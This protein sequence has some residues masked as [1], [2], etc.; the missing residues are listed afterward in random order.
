MTGHWLVGHVAH[1][2]GGQSWIVDGAAVQGFDVGLAALLS[3]GESWHNNHHAYP[4]SARLGLEPGQADPGWWL[5]LALERLGLAWAVVTTDA[6]PHRS[7]LRRVAHGGTCRLPR[8][9]VA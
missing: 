3:F 2:S 4:G 5:I 7:A 1:R 8:L 9:V 6:L